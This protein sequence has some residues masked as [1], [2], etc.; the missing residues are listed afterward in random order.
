MKKTVI[1]LCGMSFVFL[2]VTIANTLNEFEIIS[3]T[4][5][6]LKDLELFTFVINH[7]FALICFILSIKLIKKEKNSWYFLTMI[8]PIAIIIFSWYLFVGRLLNEIFS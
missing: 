7:I 2:L 3:F 6:L 5:V 8:I 4:S 1:W